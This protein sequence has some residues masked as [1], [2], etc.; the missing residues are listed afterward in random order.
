MKRWHINIVFGGLV[1]LFVTM[2]LLPSI[3]H[4]WV[5]YSGAVVPTGTYALTFSDKPARLLSVQGQRH[6][7]PHTVEDAAAYYALVLF[8][9]GRLEEVDGF[10]SSDGLRYLDVKHWQLWKGNAFD[11][12]DLRIAYDAVWQTVQ[13]DSQKYDLKKGNLFVIRYSENLTPVVTQLDAI[14]N[15]KADYEV[16]KAFKSRLQD[17]SLVQS[18]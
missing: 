13:V 1:T 15:N 2:N 5:R 11:G 6:I 7:P 14:I 12:T 17:D 4:S 9:Q 18:L 16:T 8:P 10:S 3:K